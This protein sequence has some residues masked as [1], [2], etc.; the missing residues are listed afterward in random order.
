MSLTLSISDE[1]LYSLLLEKGFSIDV[2]ARED[3]DGYTVEFRR[4]SYYV[5]TSEVKGHY[6][7]EWTPE[8]IRQDMLKKL[9]KWSGLVPM[10]KLEIV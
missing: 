7:M 6:S 2:I 10:I 4:P 1:E 3:G 5:V 8:E 9:L